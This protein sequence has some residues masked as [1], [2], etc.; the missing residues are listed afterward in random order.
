MPIEV[1]SGTSNPELA[2]QIACLLGLSLGIAQVTSFADGES[3]VQIQTPVTNKTIFIIQ[4]TAPPVNNNLIELCQMANA[5]KLAGAK[6]IV[7]VMPYFGYARQDAHTRK[8]G[9]CDSAALVM[10]ILNAASVDKI[11]TV[12][13]HN[14]SLCK[15]T[16]PK[17]HNIS[18]VDLIHNDIQRQGITT[19][20]IVAPDIGAVWRAQPLAQLLNAELA[21]I[22]KPGRAAP[23]RTLPLFGA[24]QGR[25]CIVLDDI[26][27]SGK[28]ICH[29]ISQLNLAQASKIYVY[30]THGI[31]STGALERLNAAQCK[32]IM[33][34]NSINNRQIPPQNS[35]FRFLS[36]ASA[37]AINISQISAPASIDTPRNI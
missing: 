10:G 13:L 1:F 2:T 25:A 31:L 23:S 12:D 17:I 20:V 29:A 11:I 18:T 27:D 22:P 33:L 4:A 5:L 24:V 9:E 3:K 34:F 32:N 8:P 19:P 30:A 35:K 16:K 15:S 28:T 37:I 7:A 36:I 6:S 14:P 26:I 21:I